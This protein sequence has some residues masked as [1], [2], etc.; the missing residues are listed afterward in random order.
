[1]LR[2]LYVGTLPPFPGGGAIMGA[3]LL[4]G[5]AAD[6]HAIRALAPITPADRGAPDPPGVAA[7]RFEVP[8]YQLAPDAPRAD[9]YE[10]C[11]R[12]AVA[13]MLPAMLRDERPDV[14]VAGRETFAWVAPAIART[15]GVPCMV[16]VQ[17]TTT[18]GMIRGTYPRAAEVLEH[19]RHADGVVAP[20]EHVGRFLGLPNV[21][22][23][24]NS[25]DTE[26]F[27]PRP[28]PVALL[29][30][31]AI[32]Q[33]HA[34]VTHHSNLERVKRPLDLVASAARVLARAERVTYLVMGDGGHRHEMERACEFWS[35][36]RR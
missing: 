34:V 4:A 3:E 32:P 15:N 19:Y 13:T 16:I 2:L 9:G 18:A 22:V 21:R 36:R 27:R 6:G 17:G 11:E 8:Y 14:L 31:L 29:R 33:H 24:P 26:R 12:D 25:V 35:A 28:K 20:A 10:Q 7:T 1:M 23:I 5:L 30:R